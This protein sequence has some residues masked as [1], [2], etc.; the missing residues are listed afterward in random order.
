MSTDE[1][2]LVTGMNGC[3]GAWVGLMLVR[4]GKKVVGLDRSDKDDRVRLISTPAEL[5]S[6]NVAR[7]DVADLTFLDRTLDE[8][9]VTHVVHLA[10]LQLPF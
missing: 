6:M 2:W 1:S 7:G 10:A 3:I 5:A 8:H 9:G 4:D